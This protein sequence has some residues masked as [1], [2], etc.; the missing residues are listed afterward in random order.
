MNLNN[1]VVLAFHNFERRL[2]RTLLTG[3]GIVIGIAAVIIVI[4]A[5]Q[6]VKGFLVGQLESFGSNLLQIETKIPSL[7]SQ[8]EEAQARGFG[9][10]VTT[11]TLDDM[12]AIRRHSN[13]VTNY[14]GQIGQ[15]VAQ[16]PGTKKTVNLF[17]SSAT[18]LDIDTAKV[19]RG[20]FFTEEEDVSLARVVILGSKVADDLFG[21]TDPVG[22]HIK[23]KQQNFKV[24]G[25]M[26]PRGSAF[27]FDYDV[28]VYVPIKTMQKQLLGI[29][30]VTF[31]SNQYRD[32]SKLQSTVDDLTYLLRVRHDIPLDEPDKDDFIIS[33][34][35][36][37]LS[38]FDTIIGGFTILLVALACISL[39]VGGVGIMN[40]M[41][42]SVLERTY[43]IG[44]RK[45]VG[46]RREQ[47]LKQFLVEA[48]L[49]T[50][51]GGI[52]GIIVGSVISYLISLAAGYLGF[53]WTFS[54]PLY[55]IILSV[56]FSAA[57]GLIFGLYPARRAADLDPIEAL[58]YE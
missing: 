37:V 35:E 44:L 2:A 20:R 48:V 31:I 30:Y 42:V 15:A 58:R 18:V 10:V 56:G 17:G 39:I 33:S 52:T 29:D 55:S 40:I 23:I 9:A 34:N 3:L 27:F 4:S 7:T 54:V 5:G 13:I 41:Y 11:L 47:I 45:A 8:T 43:E 12:L 49:I 19:A 50:G 25:V 24:I 1:Y 46:A 21:N 16:G 22:Q 6:G 38:I 28:Y 14:A 36:D 32:S 57:T 53:A 26:E 51:M